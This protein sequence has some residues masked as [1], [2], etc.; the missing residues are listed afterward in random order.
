MQT[1]R[2]RATGALAALLA[3]A[4]VGVLADE[5]ATASVSKAHLKAFLREAHITRVPGP[6][7]L[8]LCG[9][10]DPRAMARELGEAALPAQVVTAPDQWLLA[11]RHLDHIAHSVV[12]D[13][14]CP[15]ARTLLATAEALDMFRD[16][17]RWVLLFSDGRPPSATCSYI[18]EQGDDEG[19]RR[20]ACRTA[21]LLDGLGVLFDSDVS[22]LCDHKTTGTALAVSAYRERKGAVLRV[23]RAAVWR[24]G[25]LE[26]APPPDR[27]HLPARRLDFHEAVTGVGFVVLECG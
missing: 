27:R 23:Q 25:V 21:A 13:A 20:C 17:R 16:P 22:A 8:L 14:A 3:A 6:A 2:A 12:L 15:E 11:V 7:L 24:S 10:G 18:L 19:L 4:V 26:Q 9:E 1:H 5:N